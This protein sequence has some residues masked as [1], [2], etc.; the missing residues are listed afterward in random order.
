MTDV[1]QK[2]LKADAGT[3][4]FRQL[5]LGYA[6]LLFVPV[7]PWIWNLIAAM[8]IMRDSTN[9][10]Y[11]WLDFVISSTYLFTAG[12]FGLFYYGI[13]NS[14]CC[15]RGLD[16]LTKH[17]RDAVVSTRAFI[18]LSIPCALMSFL[19]SMSVYIRFFADTKTK[20]KYDNYTGTEGLTHLTQTQYFNIGIAFLNILIFFFPWAHAARIEAEVQS[21]NDLK[22]AHFNTP[23]RTGLFDKQSA[24]K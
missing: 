5:G 11:I 16:T 22:A 12:A 9:A 10:N 23:A 19:L 2:P 24:R 3:V 14:W 4:G 21:G 6:A 1:L 17:E 13:N 8:G 15:A 18:L 20:N 7:L